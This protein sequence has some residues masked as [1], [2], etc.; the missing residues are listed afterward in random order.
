MKRTSLSVWER[1]E[2]EEKRERSRRI[3]KGRRDI[4]VEEIFKVDCE[5]TYY[6]FSRQR[7]RLKNNNNNNKKV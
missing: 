4:W 2:E 1:K 3:D 6:L 7:R 5:A